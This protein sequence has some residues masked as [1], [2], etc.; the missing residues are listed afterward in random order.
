MW[1]H[2]LIGEGW[3]ARWGDPSAKGY[4]VGGVAVYTFDDDP[5]NA[6][7]TLGQSLG[8]VGLLLGLLLFGELLRRAAA[9]A[10]LALV[11]PTDWGALL[12]GLVVWVFCMALAGNALLSFGATTDRYVW[13]LMALCLRRPKDSVSGLTQGTPVRL[14]RDRVLGTSEGG[15]QL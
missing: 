9:E 7:L 5:H 12:C 6:L 13:V 11:T 10:Q 8:L 15:K 1:E 14:A 2:L 3:L 4:D